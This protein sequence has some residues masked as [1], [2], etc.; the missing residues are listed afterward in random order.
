MVLRQGFARTGRLCGVARTPERDERYRGTVPWMLFSAAGVEARDRGPRF[1]AV[2][3]SAGDTGGSWILYDR[4]AAPG[5]RQGPTA[6]HVKRSGL[7]ERCHLGSAPR[8]F[9]TDLPSKTSLPC[10]VAGHRRG[11]NGTLTGAP[12]RPGWPRLEHCPSRLTGLAQ[13][14][15]SAPQRFKHSEWAAPGCATRAA[16]PQGK[17]GRVGTQLRAELGRPTFHVKHPPAQLRCW[18]ILSRG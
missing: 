7:T 5:E 8:T 13:S 6:F 4:C 18:R 3:R 11:A 15:P 10:P 1:E 16:A 17:D 12:A 9:S 14:A 2:A